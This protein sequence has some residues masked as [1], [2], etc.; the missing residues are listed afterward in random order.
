MTRKQFIQPLVISIAAIVFMFGLGF[1]LAQ[2]GDDAAAQ[3]G[4]E[5]LMSGS[6][7]GTQSG[8][9]LVD[10]DFMFI[11]AH[12]DDEGGFTATTARYALDQ[13]FKG[14][15]ITLTRGE[16]GGN[17]TG[18]ELGPSLGIIRAEEL[19][20]SLETVGI[21]THYFMGLED[22]YY[23]LFAEQAQQIWGD[24]FICD[25]TRVVRLTRPE[26]IVT[27]WPGPGTHGHHQM[28]ARVATLAY[29]NAGDPSFCPEQITEEFI[30]PWQPLKLYYY[31]SGDNATVEIPTD[32]WSRTAY[33][34]YADLKALALANF[35]SQGYDQFF[36]IP[37]ENPEPEDF[38]LV[39]SRVP[40]ERPETHLLAG[41]VIEAASSPPGIGL[42]VTPE[43]Y[44]VGVDEAVT[45]TVTFNNE[46]GSPL[47][48]VQL[49]LEAPEDFTVSS[50]GD[51]T[52]ESVAP[53]ESVQ[54]S[55]DVTA[56][57]TAE[58]IGQHQLWASYSAEMEDRSISGQNRAYIEVTPPVQ[59]A[60]APLFDIAN[61]REFARETGTE[62]VIPFLL[63]RLPLTTGESNPVTV[64][65]TNLS[66]SPA[67]GQLEFDLPEGVSVEGDLSYQVPAGETLEKT[68]NLTV[69]PSVLPANEHSTTIEGT[70]S[71]TI[72][73]YTSSNQA[74]I[75]ALPTFTATRVETPPTIDGDLADMQ[76]LPSQEITSADL[77]SGEAEGPED[78]GGQF[79][80]G[81]DDENLYVGVQVTDQTVVCN[82][83][84][85]DIRGHWRSDSVEITIDPTGESANTSTTFKTGIFPCTTAGFEA[86]AERDAD[87]NQGVIEETAPGMRVASQ[88]TETGYIIETSIPWEDMPAQASTGDTIGFNVLIYDGDLA[89]ARAGANVGESRAGWA[90]VIGA[91]Q[92]IPYV[93]PEV[94]LGE[95][96]Q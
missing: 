1:V 72:A 36:T 52:F 23:T 40:V 84:P 19:R 38:V 48:N 56:P 25:T 57:D 93:W 39:K 2:D 41:A 16:G 20:R 13:G 81:Y 75:Y 29:N 92:A 82:I 77:W 66:G 21:D 34:R 33:M 11:A 69:D 80:V 37:V 86:R 43:S 6:Y 59:V 12:P 60:W 50:E 30:E 65:I 54:A 63:T 4:H 55:F 24:E 46:M 51:S 10:V 5:L 61:Y 74:D 14:T 76:S 87:A 62:W 68:V 28:A 31:A 89:D 71:T 8:L 22:F 96:S 27:M 78:T 94:T 79:Y 47:N 18:S 35:R 73:G 17:A 7:S 85:D 70:V 90:S 64:E 83:E 58:V 45:I 67:E 44:Q 49:S 88:R 26:V 32:T 91:Q 53:G 95:P 42:K 3:P 15:V 9:N